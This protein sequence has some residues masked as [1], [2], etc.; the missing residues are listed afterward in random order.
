MFKSEV[1]NYKITQQLKIS[2]LSVLKRF[3]NKITS[4]LRGSVVGYF[5]GLVPG[6]T[7]VLSTNASYSIEKKLHR[8]N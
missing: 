5:C 1:Q 6:V 3:G 2:F 4:V 7:T 8:N